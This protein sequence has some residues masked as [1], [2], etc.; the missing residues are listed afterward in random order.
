MGW[1]RAILDDGPSRAST[2]SEDNKMSAK[3]KAANNELSGHNWW[4]CPLMGC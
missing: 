3:E 2:A 1:S 4:G